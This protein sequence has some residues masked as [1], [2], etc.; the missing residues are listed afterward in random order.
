MKNSRHKYGTKLGVHFVGDGP[1]LNEL[2][3]IAKQKGVEQNVFFHGSIH[4]DEK[5]GAMLYASDMMVM[6]G[7]VGLSVNHALNFDCPITT[8]EQ[9]R[10]WAFSF[11]GN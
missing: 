9:R 8:F 10:R 3:A 2:K 11:P 6:P 5:T 7:Y 4:D 1:F